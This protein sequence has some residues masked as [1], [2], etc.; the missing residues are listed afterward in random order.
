MTSRGLGRAAIRELAARHGIRP[1]KS[2][3]QNFLVDPNLAVAIAGAAGVGEG[4]RVVEV[5]AGFGSLTL[6][7][8]DTRARVLAL[9][10]DHR[11]V[12]ALRE[13]VAD[14]ANVRILE[15]DAMRVDWAA[16]L[17]RSRWTMCSSLPYNI[18][19][20]LVLGMLASAPRVTRFVVLVQREVGERLAA[21]PGEEQYGAVSVRVGFRA[22]AEVVRRVPARV[23]WPEPTVESVVVR[24]E[25][26][27]RPPVRVAPERL[28]RVVDAGFAQRRKTMRSALRRLGLDRP[29]DVLSSCGLDPNVRAEELSLEEFSR[30]AE[31]IPG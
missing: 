9:E 15:A 20:P 10:F 12:L 2:L 18:A 8:A 23:F 28:W 3:G 21:Q 24:L 26:R 22:T 30:I 11:L 6:A 16:V 19:V 31:V 1:T 14:S 27:A 25:R 29:D 7:L 4:D 5:G 17:G 13:T